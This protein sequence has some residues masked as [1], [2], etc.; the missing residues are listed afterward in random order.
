M[1]HMLLEVTHESWV[2]N[3]EQVIC[4]MLFENIMKYFFF[5]SQLLFTILE[6]ENDGKNLFRTV[7]AYTEHRRIVFFLI[8]FVLFDFFCLFSVF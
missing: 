1:C 2:E 4:H 5:E 8:F 6:F 7:H 3:I